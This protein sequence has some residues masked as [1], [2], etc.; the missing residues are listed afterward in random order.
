MGFALLSANL[1][2]RIFLILV[3]ISANR[4]I[5]YRQFLNVYQKT[6]WTLTSAV[7]LRRLKKTRFFLAIDTGH[8]PLESLE[9]DIWKGDMPDVNKEVSVSSLSNLVADQDVSTVV[10]KNTRNNYRLKNKHDVGSVVSYQG[11]A[12][13]LVSGLNNDCVPFQRIIDEIIKPPQKRI[14]DDCP[15]LKY[16]QCESVKIAPSSC[17][18]G[19][20][21]Y[22]TCQHNNVT[23]VVYI[24]SDSVD[25]SAQ[26]YEQVSCNDCSTMYEVVY[27]HVS[28]GYDGP[29]GATPNP[30]LPPPPC[31]APLNITT[32]Y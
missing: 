7:Q 30:D 6:A 17:R 18:G 27:G 26:F 13:C 23:C 4:D 20:N 1:R 14:S 16:I 11:Q 25:L 28:Y 21:A 15:K 12:L 9:F 19:N 31:Y 2:K 8:L 5:I 22:G 24:D 10:G 29:D 32:V 3:G